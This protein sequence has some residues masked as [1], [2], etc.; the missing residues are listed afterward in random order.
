MPV[1]NPLCP[2]YDEWPATNRAILLCAAVGLPDV[3]G[4]IKNLQDVGRS[5]GWE[6]TQDLGVREML[7]ANT[8]G[9]IE[10]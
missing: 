7:G 5:I 1:F 3:F 4:G 6:Q 10:E 8:D 9:E 2:R